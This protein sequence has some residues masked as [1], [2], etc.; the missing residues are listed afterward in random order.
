M[1]EYQEIIN[2]LVSIEFF[3]DSLKKRATGL[4]VRLLA[5]AP[6]AAPSGGLTESQIAKLR[7][8]RENHIAKKNGNKKSA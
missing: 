7:A 8:N 4:R 6:G 1:S 3:L 2:E 5:E